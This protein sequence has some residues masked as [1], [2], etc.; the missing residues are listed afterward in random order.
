MR[1]K[2]TECWLAET[3]G[4]FFL[5][6]KA[7]GN[8]EGMIT[9]CWLA[10]HACIKLVSRFKR[11]LKR[12]F[13]NVSQQGSVFWWKSKSIL[14]RSLKN[15]WVGTSGV[16]RSIELQN[17]MA[18]K[19]KGNFRLRFTSGCFTRLS[20]TGHLMG[21]KNSVN[22]VGTL[23]FRSGKENFGFKKLLE[24]VWILVYVFIGWWSSFMPLQTSQNRW[25][26]LHCLSF[27]CRALN[28]L[29]LLCFVYYYR[30]F[31]VLLLACSLT[32][33]LLCRP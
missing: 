30:G 19:L 33:W 3:Q 24:L 22:C 23:N 10:E 11:I 17:F 8:Q 31:S 25:I 4:I 26:K 7:L 9:L 28:E 29:N 16:V 2:I 15:V 6:K 13:R 21:V 12:N 18:A 20:I 14:I 5:I 1:D 32:H 27:V